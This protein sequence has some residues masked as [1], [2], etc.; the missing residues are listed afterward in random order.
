MRDGN[1]RNIKDYAMFIPNQP[2]VSHV[3]GK[4]R[5]LLAV[6]DPVSRMEGA[7]FSK[8]SKASTRRLVGQS[9]LKSLRMQ[10][11]DQVGF[12][13]QVCIS[14]SSHQASKKL[15]PDVSKAGR[16]SPQR[17]AN[18]PVNRSVIQKTKTDESLGSYQNENQTDQRKSR[19]V[20]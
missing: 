4:S 18:H 17:H 15:S 20:Y 6:S 19:P 7:S 8:I 1:F 12:R 9:D 16:P 14:M 2:S 11:R 10:Q 3:S 13:N 5:M